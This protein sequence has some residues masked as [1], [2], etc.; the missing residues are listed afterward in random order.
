MA[1]TALAGKSGSVSGAGANSATEIT[2]WS[3]NVQS[4]ALE[5]TSTASAGYREFINGLIGA[6]G[7]FTCIGV[8]P[9]VSTVNTNSISLLTASGGTTISGLCIITSVD[10]ASEVAG[11]V[12]F[13]ANFTF[14]GP[15]TVS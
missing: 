5:A 10:Y 12:T 13:T 7:T 11:V 3:V 8:K 1:T 9:T 2:G 14:T 6:T 15:I 4:D